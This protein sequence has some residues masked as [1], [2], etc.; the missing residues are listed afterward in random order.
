[1]W[2]THLYLFKLQYNFVVVEALFYLISDKK[3]TMRVAIRRKPLLKCLLTLI[4]IVLL[5]TFFVLSLSENK[6]AGSN[7]NLKYKRNKS[8]PPRIQR[9]AQHNK[10]YD[11]KNGISSVQ[12]AR[13]L[14]DEF[15]KPTF[16][17]EDIKHEPVK[18]SPL[19]VYVFE[20]HHEGR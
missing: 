14:V 2:L 3:D 6:Q 10:T 15:G 7:F 8:R 16:E 12:R 9:K 18:N 5:V 17:S 1:M 11:V 4:V 20:E 13:R 19:D